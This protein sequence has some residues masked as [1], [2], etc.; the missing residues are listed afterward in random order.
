MPH[1]Y[2]IGD[3][4]LIRSDLVHNEWYGSAYV[5]RDMM[6]LLGKEATITSRHGRDSYIL[7]G[8]HWTWTGEMI[9]GLAPSVTTGDSTMTRATHIGTSSNGEPWLCR[10]DPEGHWL[11]TV[12]DGTYIRAEVLNP[13]ER[14]GDFYDLREP[15]RSAFAPSSEEM[16]LLRDYLG[17]SSPLHYVDSPDWEIV[18][19]SPSRG[20]LSRSSIAP[21]SGRQ[22]IP[23]SL[24]RALIERARIEGAATGQRSY[25]V[26]RLLQLRHV[27]EGYW[28]DRYFDS[29]G[30]R[31]ALTFM[32]K[33]SVDLFNWA[34]LEERL[35][36]PSET[37]SR[38]QGDL[39]SGNWP[40]APPLEADTL[41]S[42][43]SHYPVLYCLVYDNTTASNRTFEI[44]STTLVQSLFGWT[45]SPQGHSFWASIQRLQERWLRGER[46]HGEIRELL[47]SIHSITYQA[48]AP[49]PAPSSGPPA[50]SKADQLVHRYG[51]LDYLSFRGAVRLGFELE[52]QH[53]SGVQDED[54]SIDSWL[55]DR[56]DDLYSEL[57]DYVKAEYIYGNDLGSRELQNLSQSTIETII[58]NEGIDTLESLTGSDYLEDAI[59]ELLER[60]IRR[61]PEDWGYDPDDYDS[62]D[63]NY[64]RRTCRTRF[65]ELGYDSS[66][67]GVEIRTRDGGV[68][69]GAF[70]R[71]A[72]DAFG[73]FDHDIDTNCSFHIHLSLPGLSP[74]SG[75]IVRR[76]TQYILDHQD[77]LPEEVRKR[78]RSSACSEYASISKSGSGKYSFI[79]IHE[80]GTWEFRAFGNVS[81]A[82]SARICADLAVRALYHAY[83]IRCGY[84][85]D[86]DVDGVN[87]VDAANEARRTNKSASRV[88]MYT[89]MFEAAELRAKAREMLTF[90]ETA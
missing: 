58:S 83:R 3:R 10:R 57:D 77:E 4:V 50:R 21:P 42:F 73:S 12:K 43:Y 76:M 54:Y 56:L 85:P 48:P 71:A 38:I 80:Q 60:D 34:V 17:Y 2:E 59:L 36:L 41:E 15:W 7:E 84:E 20:D 68:A 52:T 39:D 9:E 19:C 62:M 78:L 6:D 40:E 63:R 13:E 79:H 67:D 89:A 14:P 45:D 8:S 16:R 88:V 66:V 86:Y 31:G 18:T 25:W 51:R 5:T 29:A 22:E 24:V 30:P 87:W 26:G 27:Y 1:A 90:Y 70:N 11:G 64:F 69:W 44:I 74:K 33:E 49:A 82:A 61:S 23:V 72:V 75:K 28:S 35:G 46:P 81:S 65:L 37:F 47:A 55:E 32:D 53:T